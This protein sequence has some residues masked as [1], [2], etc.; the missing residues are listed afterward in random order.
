VCASASEGKYHGTFI[1]LFALAYARDNVF[2]YGAACWNGTRLIRP[3]EASMTHRLTL[4]ET[5]GKG[6]QLQW[7]LI[8]GSL[9]GQRTLL[10]ISVYY[11][12]VKKESSIS[13]A[14]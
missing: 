3:S 7:R 9:A 1:V 14:F 2:D 6:S 11:D 10:A 12:G 8:P 5:H 13:Q 4:A